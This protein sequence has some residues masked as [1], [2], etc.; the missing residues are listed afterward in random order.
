MADTYEQNLGQKTSLT[1][2]DFIRVV[3]SDNVS[4]KQLVS[5]VADVVIARYLNIPAKGISNGEDLNNYTTVGTYFCDSGAIASSLSNCPISTV[6]RMEVSKGNNGNYTIQTITQTGTNPPTY[7]VRMLVTST[8]GAWT[9]MPTRGEI[10]ALDSNL[11]VLINNGTDLNTLIL[12]G[13]DNKKIKVYRGE[14]IS[15]MINKPS[16][17]SASWPFCLMLLP[18]GGTYTKQ[19]L[20]IYG[21]PTT[22]DHVYVRTQT[23]LSG[24]ITWTDWQQSPTRAEIDALNTHVPTTSTLGTLDLN[25]LPLDKPMRIYLQNIGS[26]ATVERHYPAAQVAGFLLQFRASDWILQVYFG[27]SA[28]KIYYRQWYDSMSTPPNWSTIS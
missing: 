7:Y 10:N 14:S 1:T 12:A 11:G 17:I 24:S 21:T 2:T 15:Q 25:T 6:F 27:F 20:H 13:N 16:D 5:N 23:Y 18:V 3:G 28:S 19:I 9:K 4:Y 22:P 8:W 26:N